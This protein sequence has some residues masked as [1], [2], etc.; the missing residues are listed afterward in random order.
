[1]ADDGVAAEIG[2]QLSGELRVALSMLMSLGG[3]VPPN[4]GTVVATKRIGTLLI[5]GSA[6]R[7]S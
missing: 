5:L 4:P 2:G 6:S 7:S 1:V 3:A